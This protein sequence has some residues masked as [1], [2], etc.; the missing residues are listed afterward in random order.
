MQFLKLFIFHTLHVCQDPE[1]SRFL[2]NHQ[3]SLEQ[4][5]DDE[6]V[7][8]LIFLFLSRHRIYVY[9]YIYMHLTGLVLLELSF[10]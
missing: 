9:S 7:S 10:F 2:D 6:S 5:R 8:Y 3:K 4:Y 1:F